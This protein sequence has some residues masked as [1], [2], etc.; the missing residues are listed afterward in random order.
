MRNLG[1]MMDSAAAIPKY[2]LTRRWLTAAVE[3]RRMLV[4]LV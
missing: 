3:Q 2:R 1:L 4:C